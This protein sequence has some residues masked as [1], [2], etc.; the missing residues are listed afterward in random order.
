M[1][2]D[3]RLLGDLQRII[4]LDAQIAH[5]TLQLR[6]AKKQLHGPQVP[7]ATVDQRCLGPTHRVCAVGTRL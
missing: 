1:D 5:G 2:S 4:N 7:C 6:V 3:I